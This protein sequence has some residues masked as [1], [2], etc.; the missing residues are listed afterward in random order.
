MKEE[1]FAKFL[2]R[3]KLIVKFSRY[4]N[5]YLASQQHCFIALGKILQRVYF[6]YLSSNESGSTACIPYPESTNLFE[7]LNVVFTK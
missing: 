5:G 3:R 4:E 7:Q 1:V 6:V 2:E